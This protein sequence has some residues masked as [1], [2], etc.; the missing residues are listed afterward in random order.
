V[1]KIKEN[2][3][4]TLSALR[5]RAAVF[6]LDGVVTRTETLHAQAWKEAFDPFL[7]EQAGGGDFRPF[8]IKDDYLNYVDGRPRLDGIRTFLASRGIERPEGQPDDPEDAGTV[9]ALGNKKN[10]SFLALLKQGVKLYEPAIELIWKLKNFGLA[11]AIVSSSKNCKAILENANIT[12]LFDT[13]VDGVD[14]QHLDLKGKPA[15]DLFLEAARRLG[16]DPGRSMAFEDAVA[17]V[18]A[19]KA[20]AFGTVIGVDRADHAKALKAAGADY[21]VTTLAALDIRTTTTELPSALDAFDRIEKRIRDR[22]VVLYLDYDGTLT[23]IVSHPEDAHLSEAMR[24]LLMKLSN[25]CTIAVVSGRGLGDIK[26]RVGIKGIYYAGSHGFEIEGPGIKMEYDEAKPFIEKLDALETEL[27]TALE[28]VKGAYVERKKYSIALH[29]RNVPEAQQSRFDQVADESLDRYPELRKT[30]GKKVYELQPDLDWDKGKAIEWIG[31]ALRVDRTVSKGIYIGDDITDED[32]FEAIQVHG[33][34]VLVDG[35]E[36]R[37]TAAHYRLEGVEETQRFLEALSAS[38][39]KGNIW[40]LA[41]NGYEPDREKLREVL[42]ALGNGYFVT[43]AA[44]PGTSAGSVHYP[45]TYLAG[46]YNRLKSGIAGREVKN[47]DLVNLPDWLVLKFRIDGGEWCSIDKADILFFRQ[48][49][50]IKEGVLHRLVH[51][52][53]PMGRET[54][55]I[56]RRLVHMADKHIAALELTIIPVNWSGAID[57][58]SGINGN[59]KNEGVKRYSKLASRHLKLLES[60]EA[61]PETLLLKMQTVQSELTVAQTVRTRIYRDDKLLEAEAETVKNRAYI[62]RRYRVGPLEAGT[63]L[64]IERSLALYTSKDSAISNPALEALLAAQEARRFASLLDSHRVAWKQLWDRYDFRLDLNET[65]GDHFV[66]RTLHLYAFHLLQTASIHSL[67]MDVGIP[68]RG[69]H[70]E[71]YRGHIFWDEVIIFPFFN[72]RLPHIT[73]SLIRYRYRRLRE[74]RRAAAELGYRGAMF[75]WQSGSNGKEETQKLHLNPRSRRWLEDNSH[76]QRHVNSAIVYTIWHYY[77]VSADFDFL[78][79]YG[80]EMILEIARFWS[81]IATYNETEERYEIIGVMGPDEYH[82]GYP[83]SDTPGLRNNAYTNIMAVFVLNKALEMQQLLSTRSFNE[84]CERLQ[85]EA[86]EIERWEQIRTRMKIPFHDEGIISQFE[87]Y[88]TL[89]ELDWGYYRKEYESI[90]RLDRILESEQKS[91]NRYKVSKQ[92]DVLMLFYLFS[93]EELEGLF[94]QLGYG[95]DADMIRNNIDY[96]LQRTSNGS[97]L[98]R[99]VHAWVNAR[100]DRGKS[101]AFFKEA[102]NTDIEDIQGGTTPEGIHLGAMS[103]SID[104]IQRC[105]TGL[106]ARDNV[107]RLNPSLPEE[108]RKIELH[109]HYRRQWLHLIIRPEQLT[110]RALD[111]CAKP[112]AVEVKG[113]RFM[114]ESG[115]VREILYPKEK[116]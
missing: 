17:G 65:A 98:S 43:R 7:K 66:V 57:V 69:W 116:L 91:T 87:G 10:R 46:G 85:I 86:V 56:E 23:P 59:V 83:G 102:L 74:A 78:Y 103:G 5:Y 82:D 72:Y 108:L 62:A 63:H 104:I 107:L 15:P 52:C 34:G 71:A 50:D 111:S 96:Y 75:P 39:E 97:S 90:E 21:V 30:L 48:E 95:L 99:V 101:W 38:I 76:L 3:S 64:H 80:A 25:Q 58:E 61:G 13:V 109:L 8:D 4:F 42:C 113:E 31:N 33:I 9:Y 35:A 89:E 49:L 93:N 115:S 51:L 112:I 79:F 18:E 106:E 26:S 92:A 37:E 68:A 47:E 27:K 6:D 12:S 55:V 20:G 2:H 84:L 24:S 14:L 100:M 110:I 88:E 73:R 41:Y 105:Y 54:K 44:F 36:T 53:D 19:A 22:E 77:E 81:S 94:N 70:G 45:G 67:D 32:A 29:Y 16:A 1:K 60:E 11:I 40:S 28:G 114:L